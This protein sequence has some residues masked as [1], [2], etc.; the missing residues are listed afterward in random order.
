MMLGGISIEG[1]I[2]YMAWLLVG[3]YLLTR[4]ARSRT[5]N[6][7]LTMVLGTL[8]LLIPPL[9]ALVLLYL[10]FRPRLDGTES[11]APTGS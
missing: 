3:L 6:P 11:A 9:G 8:A 5:H 2:A 10:A 1:M 7:S 4:L